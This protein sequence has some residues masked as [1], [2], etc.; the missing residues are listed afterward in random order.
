MATRAVIR[1][2]LAALVACSAAM[3]AGSLA[4]AAPGAN[5]TQWQVVGGARYNGVQPLL[6]VGWA[7]NRLWMATVPRD[8]PV[9][10]SARLSGGKLTDVVHTRVPADLTRLPIVDGQLVFARDN[11]ERMMTAPLLA[12]GQVGTSKIV[13]DELLVRGQEAAPKLAG[14]SILDGVRVGDRTVWALSGA[15]EAR[16]IGG[17]PQ[18]FLVCCGESGAATDLTR[19]IHRGRG[20][21]DVRIGVGT[22]GRIWLAWGDTKDR[23]GALILELDRSTLAPRTKP[24][25]VPGVKKD[26]PF[27]LVCAAFCRLV[28]Q[29]TAGDI[30]SWRPG[31]RSPTLVVSHIRTR[32]EEHAPFQI[33]VPHLRSDCERG[34]HG[35][36]FEGHLASPRRTLEDEV[37]QLVVYATATPILRSV[38]ATTSCTA[39]VWPVMTAPLPA[40]RQALG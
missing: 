24:Q 38:F 15:E 40:A 7:S 3:L 39:K 36:R 25:V 1:A 9:L 14:V 22:N 32:N 29:T 20:V 19:F 33:H 10:V 11:G 23:R 17:S 13:S 8:E 27:D 4:D 6:A 34:V 26:G 35:V 30:V 2:G 37:D 18:F 16:G 5:K 31:E 28:L 12:N 21:F